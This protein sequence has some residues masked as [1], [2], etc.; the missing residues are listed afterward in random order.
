V[1]HEC[2]TVL[3]ACGAQVASAGA[4]GAAGFD[5]ASALARLEKHRKD[6]SALA[7]RPAHFLTPGDTPAEAALNLARTA[8]RR[9]ERSLV[10]LRRTVPAVAPEVA[11]YLNRLS[12]LLFDMLRAEI[13]GK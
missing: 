8:V 1:L 11:P 3:L 4:P 2:Q 5:F 6:L 12:D 13:A 10:A 9:A 7:P